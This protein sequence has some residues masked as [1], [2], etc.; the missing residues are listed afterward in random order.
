MNTSE[1]DLAV[2]CLGIMSVLSVGAMVMYWIIVSI[3]A[4]KHYERGYGWR[5]SVRLAMS[6]LV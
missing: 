1:I 3:F 2:L 5:E 6:E 4:I